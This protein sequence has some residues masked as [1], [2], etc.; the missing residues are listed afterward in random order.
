MKRPYYFILS[1]ASLPHPNFRQRV[2]EDIKNYFNLAS[3]DEVLLEMCRIL[4]RG[5]YYLRFLYKC[6]V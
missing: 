4:D 5:L 3:V 6:Q 1:L 2:A